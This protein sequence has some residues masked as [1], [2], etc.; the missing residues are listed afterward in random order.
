MTIG[1]V[2]VAKPHGKSVDIDFDAGGTVLH[3]KGESDFPE[4]VSRK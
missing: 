3:R 2:K 4:D 1:G